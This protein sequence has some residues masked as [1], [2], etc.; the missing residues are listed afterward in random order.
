MQAIYNNKGKTV[1]W[2]A[3]K[4]I[5]SL[6]GDY[7]G[8]VQ[9]HWVYNLKSKCC[10]SLKQSI[11]RDLQG[12]VVAFVKGAKQLSYLPALKPTP[13]KPSRRAKP[14]LRKVANPP[15]VKPAKKIWSALS[16]SQYIA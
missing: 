1:G 6:K 10:G 2:I 13:S 9:D 4:D 7:I 15:A 3:D 12:K 11:F 8:F 14:V 16:W 5:Y